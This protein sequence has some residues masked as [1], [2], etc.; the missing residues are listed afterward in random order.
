M[1]K[2]KF[3][4]SK[5]D[6]TFLMA[7][8]LARHMNTAHASPKKKAAAKR[9][10]KRVK[11]ARRRRGVASQLGL[12]NMSLEELGKLMVAIRAEARRRIAEIQRAMK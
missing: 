10:A 7:A 8:H 2:R 12:S 9:K 3:R 4:C 6:R 11:A 5:C 1:A